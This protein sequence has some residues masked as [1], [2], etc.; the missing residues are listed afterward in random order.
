LFGVYVDAQA[1]SSSLVDVDGVEFAS[2]DLVHHGLAG[3]F[4]DL[5]GIGEAYPSL[6]NGGGDPVPDGL[7]DP[8]PPGSSGGELLA[9]KESVGQPPVDGDFADAE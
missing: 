3:E 9:G 7:V 5:G 8:D 1:F 4:E 2:L 6:G